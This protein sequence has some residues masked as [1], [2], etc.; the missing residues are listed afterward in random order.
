MA[1]I[2]VT[3]S[4]SEKNRLEEMAERNQVSLSRLIREKLFS[5]PWDIRPA[6]AS[7]DQKMVDCHLILPDDLVRQAYENAVD[8]GMTK[9]AYFT[10]VLS[11][12]GRPV[13]VRF[14]Y[15]SSVEEIAKLN[16]VIHD[17]D[18]LAG[19]IRQSGK[20]YDTDLEMAVEKIHEL[21]GDLVTSVN[22]LDK[23]SNALMEKVNRKLI[24]GVALAKE[25]RH[26]DR[27]DHPDPQQCRS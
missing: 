18:L 16:A 23:K 5:P 3:V 20:A 17:I 11:Q 2:K 27:K 9:S 22:I 8:L 4:E 14:D 19:M 10:L 26:G 1:Q 6:R 7:P 13:L 21:K 24:S 12:K 25:S 15:L